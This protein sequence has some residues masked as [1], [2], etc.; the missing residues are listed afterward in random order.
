MARG[1]SLRVYFQVGDRNSRSHAEIPLETEIMRLLV[2]TVTL[3]LICSITHAELGPD[4]A[5]LQQR[6]ARGTEFLQSSQAA[7]GSWT[8]PA[9]PGITGL[10]TY[11]LLQSGVPANDP[12][13]A[14]ALS[15]LESFIQADGG[16][17]HPKTAH[18]NY[19]TSI[20][21]LALNAANSGGKYDATIV[22]A[23]E[24][25]KGI[26]WDEA[27][28]SD[29]EHTSFGGAGYG[30]HKRP[31]LSNTTF[32]I[33]ALKAA[34]VSENDP[35][36]K[37]ALTFV[38]RCQNLEGEH[39][40][41]PFASL[42]KDGGFYYTPADGGSS[43][44][45]MNPDGGLR[46]YASMTYAGLKSMIYAGVSPD[47]VRVQAAKNWIRNFYTIEENPGMG[48]QGL[49]Y[50]YHT[51]AKTLAVLKVNEFEDAQG[52][53]HDWRLEL[54]SHLF[55]KQQENGSW[56]NPEVRWM[57]GDAN[58]VTAYTLMALKYCDPEVSA[59]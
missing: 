6:V 26:Q 32:F 34:G 12:T 14:K 19:E 25:L 42:V 5:G 57:E 37:N 50:Y 56:T 47:D 13:V 16:I 59:E 7:D 1:N 44:A 54:A 20:I 22:K 38:S 3:A 11:S 28:G 51:F 43:Q 53:K 24:F 27:E 4:R 45:G 29:P 31:D 39:N 21:L 40:T 35:A 41:T 9:A 2:S 17:Y 23:A 46:S 10:V 15:H 49:F 30:S 55:S 33:E 48:Q 36:F 52:V 18:K 8:S 58:L